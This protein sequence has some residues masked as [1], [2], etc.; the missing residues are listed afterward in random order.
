MGKAATSLLG[1]ETALYGIDCIGKDHKTKG[2]KE[3]RGLTVRA[4]DAATPRPPSTCAATASGA[5]CRT[6]SPTE[7]AAESAIRVVIGEVSGEE[8][9]RCPWFIHC[10]ADSKQM[11]YDTPALK[12]VFGVFRYKQCVIIN[13][14]LGERVAYD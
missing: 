12:L 14:R 10:T 4:S 3:R 2:Y 7:S 9:S 1:V 5:T 13:G 8:V 11:H 6:A